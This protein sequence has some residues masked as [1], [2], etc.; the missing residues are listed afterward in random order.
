MTLFNQIGEK[1]KIDKIKF[2]DGETEEEPSEKDLEKINL[3]N[4]GFQ[5]GK[6]KDLY[7]S[8]V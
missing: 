6:I 8:F 1:N 5:G 3:E 2:R 4:I 7:L